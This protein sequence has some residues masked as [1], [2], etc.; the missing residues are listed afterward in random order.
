[1]KKQDYEQLREKKQF[2]PIWFDLL[3]ASGFAGVLPTGGIV[4]RRY[5]PEAHPVQ[6]N[7]LFGV[8]DPKEPEKMIPQ[9]QIN[10][11]LLVQDGVQVLLQKE[12]SE[13]DEKPTLEVIFYVGILKGTY[14]L[15]FD[16]FDLRD[17]AF[18]EYTGE[19]AQP[20]I[21]R[22]KDLAKEAE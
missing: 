19:N 13:E 4:D 10:F 8:A 21:T 15:Y 12:W 11:R 1:M 3:N 16:N 7:S 17:N 14:R 20:L 18:N 5:Y 9:D 2:E 6:R 22:F